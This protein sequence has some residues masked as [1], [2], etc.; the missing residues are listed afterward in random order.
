[1]EKEL[2]AICRRVCQ[3]CAAFDG[4]VANRKSSVLM[5][6]SGWFLF[7]FL[8]LGPLLEM[9]REANYF[10]IKINFLKY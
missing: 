4:I 2:P 8:E 7:S 5:K 6:G 9:E 1:V 10:S 3:E